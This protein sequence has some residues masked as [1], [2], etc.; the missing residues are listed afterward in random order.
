[1]LRH[2]GRMRPRRPFFMNPQILAGR[3]ATPEPGQG[4]CYVSSSMTVRTEVSAPVPD[5]STPRRP[6]YRLQRD[7]LAAAVAVMGIIDL[8]SALLSHPP[9]RLLALRHLVPTDVLDTSRTFTLLAGALLL[10]TAWG[11]RRGKRRAF[12]MAL[13]L[14][15]VSVP[16]NLLKALDVEEATVASALL[17]ALGVSADAFRVRSRELP[18][19]TLSRPLA[20]AALALVVYA[21]GGSWMV[22]TIT[23]HRPSIRLAFA[24]AA[25]RM[26]GFGDAVMVTPAQMPPAERR[27][28]RWYLRSL[29]LLSLTLVLGAALAALGPATHRRRRRDEM[30]RVAELLRR[31]GDGS[32][33]SFA[34]ADDTD[35]FFSRN[36]RAVVPYHFESDALLAIGDPL[37]PA[38]ELAPMLADFAEYCSERDWQFAFFQARGERLPLYRSLGWRAWHLGEDAVIPVDRWSLEG[39]ARGDVRRMSRKAAEAGIEVRHFRPDDHAFDLAHDPD[40][41]L[42]QLRAVSSDWLRERAG[43]EKGFCMGEFHPAA[44]PQVWLAVAWNPSRSR[45]EAF[46]SWNPVP[47]RNGWALDWM[48][49]RSDAAT[50][51]MELLVVRSIEE[52]R[53]RGDTFLSLSLSALVKVEREDSAGEAAH[54]ETQEM[55]RVRELL[56]EHLSRFYDFRGLFHW[57]R[58]FDP[59]FEPRYLVVPNAAGLSRV[60]VALVRAQSPGGLMAYVRTLWPRRHEPAATMGDDEPEPAVRGGEAPKQA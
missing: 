28:V 52:A 48:R 36:G 5:A 16:V 10:V 60:V 58:K 37:G 27:M 2:D 9:D 57:K 40:G 54:A 23:G 51:A 59:E 3:S 39:S 29:P 34:L 20:W 1:M 43:D 35:Y 31:Y 30:A 47:A 45:V 11:L 50:G 42:D 18:P 26:F 44:L 14:C 6:S 46:V 4:A 17:F 12:V 49:R 8:L 41:L 19:R 56:I 13:L 24:D 25:H 38:D 7:V 32:V 53:R 15:A 33:S 22:K 55:A 21:V